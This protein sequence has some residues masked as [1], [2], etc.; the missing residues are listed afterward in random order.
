MTRII[1]ALI[2]AGA[3]AGCASPKQTKSSYT[4]VSGR[5]VPINGSL[6]V[7]GTEIIKVYKTGRHI[8]SSNSNIMHEAGQMYVI[9]R[10][11]TWNVR[12]NTPVNS[13]AFKNRLRPVN[14]QFE[15][16]KK[17]QA[18]LQNTNQVM[19]KLG[20]QMLKSRD[21]LQKISKST[22]NEKDL[23]PLVEELGKEQGKIKR[24]LAELEQ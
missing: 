20:N 7:R 3:L 10:S 9:S 1:L 2:I 11:P 12:P 6:T 13:P 24:K 15:N 19:K 21:E 14:I 5:N 4:A 17:Q 22:K 23:K 16:L 8:D 18:L